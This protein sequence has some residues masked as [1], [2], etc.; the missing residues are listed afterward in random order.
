MVQFCKMDEM[1]PRLQCR[2]VRCGQLLTIVWIVA[3][4]IAATGIAQAPP[5]LNSPIVPISE[6][7]NEPEMSEAAPTSLPPAQMPPV[8]PQVTY[9]DGELTIIAENCSLGDI[10]AAV[11]RL[12][13]VRIDLPSTANDERMAARLGPGSTRDVITRLLSFTDFNY[14]M[15]SADNDPDELQSIVLMTRSISAPK[16]S[17]PAAPAWAQRRQA[18]P[19][20]PAPDADGVSITIERT[21]ITSATAADAQDASTPAAVATTPLLLRTLAP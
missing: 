17:S 13:G 3:S 2:I 6:P 18:R 9:R 14:I 8:P 12:T 4:T 20:D 19:A 10:L 5:R 1:K 15:Q 11:H 21:P 16:A 7:L